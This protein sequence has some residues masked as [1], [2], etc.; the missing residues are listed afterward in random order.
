MWQEVQDGTADITTISR[1]NGKTSV[2][3]SVTKQSDGN[4]VDVSKRFKKIAKLVSDY[5][6]SIEISNCNGLFNLYT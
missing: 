2:S 4:A 6:T 1:L 5:K 3:I